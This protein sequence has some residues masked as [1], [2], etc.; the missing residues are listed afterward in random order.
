MGHQSKQYLLRHLLRSTCAKPPLAKQVRWPYAHDCDLSVA[1]GRIFYLKREE[2]EYLL[3]LTN[4][5]PAARL[6]D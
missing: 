3:Q 2:S 4:L 1:Q 6:E 5:S